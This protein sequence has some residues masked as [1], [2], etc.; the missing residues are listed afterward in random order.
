MILS[1]DDIEFFSSQD[2]W[3]YGPMYDLCMYL[4]KETSAEEIE[5]TVFA[6]RQL[7]RWD[8]VPHPKLLKSLMIIE[9]LAIVGLVHSSRKAS[10]KRDFCTYELSIYPRQ[11]SR[12]LGMPICNRQDWSENWGKM[13]PFRVALFH[14]ALFRIVEDVAAKF[15]LLSASINIEDCGMALPYLRDGSVCLS[16]QVAEALNFKSAPI[17]GAPAYFVSASLSEALSKTK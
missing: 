13:E 5:S 11:Y 12:A 6:A 2:N 9:G 10:D 1:T 14:G 15:S 16:P 17:P 3:G 7:T 8:G 4:P